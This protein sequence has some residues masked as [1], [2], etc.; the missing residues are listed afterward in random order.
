MIVPTYQ[1]FINNEWVE[2]LSKETFDD[3]NPYTG[4]IYAVV[5]EGRY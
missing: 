4:E 2:S 5:A 1:L 3:I